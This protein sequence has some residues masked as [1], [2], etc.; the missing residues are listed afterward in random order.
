MSLRALFCLFKAIAIAV[1]KTVITTNGA[2]ESKHNCAIKI[3]VEKSGLWTKWAVELQCALLFSCTV[4]PEIVIDVKLNKP[5]TI[6]VETMAVLRIFGE[7]RPTFT[8]KNDRDKSIN[9]YPYQAL[10]RY[11][12]GHC[13]REME[14]I[15]KTRS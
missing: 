3:V 15:A 12:E 7:M 13:T 1:Y 14:Q 8:G 2:R 9:C 4:T 5:A 11:M 6:Q 10:S